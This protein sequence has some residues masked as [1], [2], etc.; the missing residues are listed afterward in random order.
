[1]EKVDMNFIA[2]K[3]GVSRA[4]VSRVI[5]EPQRVK[6][7][8]RAK[9]RSIMAEYNYV[10]SHSAADFSRK[11]TSMFAL[12][13]PTVKSSIYAQFIDGMHDGIRGSR[14]DL[15]IGYTNYEL[16]EEI[17]YLKIFRERRMAGIIILGV[18]DATQDLIYSIASRGEPALISTWE[19]SPE[20]PISCVGFNNYEAS[21]KMTKYLVSL[22][23]T[24]IGLITGPLTAAHRVIRR[25]KGYQ[26]ALTEAN[27]E[28][29]PNYVVH[30]HPTLVEGREA[31]IR[32]MRLE[33]PPSAVFAAS[34]ALAIGVLKALRDLGLNVPDD[35]SVA[36]F[37]NIDIASY[38]FPTLTTVM[39]PAYEMGLKAVQQLICQAEDPSCELK[40]YCLDTELIIR[41][42]CMPYRS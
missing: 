25:H 3:A 42:S 31:A 32:L 16:D 29:N 17:E 33:S 2:E 14:Y 24:R 8:T 41:D 35:V 28:Y 12:I 37:D 13:I 19:Y 27:I 1:M 21:K 7:R 15:A 38:C 39:V 18:K 9:V 10:Y 4:T 40:K 23:H 26:D 22:G 30:A 11:K 6:E 20:Y 5:H 36:G 34:D